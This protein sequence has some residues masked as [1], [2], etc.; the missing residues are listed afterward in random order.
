MNKQIVQDYY[1]KT[2]QSS[3][4]LKTDACATSAAPPAHIREALAAVHDDV[5]SRY[6][7]CGIAI[8]TQLEGLNILDLGSGSGRDVYALAKLA[9]PKGRVTGVD[10]TPEQLAV[11][12]EHEAWHADA[13]GYKEPTTRFIEGD[14]EK[15]ADL[16]LEP[17]SFD[18]IVSNCVINLCADKPAVFRAAYDLLKPGGEL[19]FSD[20]YA[21]R[22]VPDALKEDPVLLGECLSGALYWTDFLAMAKQ[23]GFLDPRVVEHRPLALLDPRIK[24]KLA[25]TRF[26][27]VTAR[28]FKLPDLEPACEDYGQAVIYKGGLAGAERSFEL[29]AEHQIEV[30]HVF[31]VCGNTRD[32]LMKTRFA[33][34]FEVIGDGTT[35]YGPFPGCKPV[36]VFAATDTESS[37]APVGG[38]C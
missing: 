1:G 5:S 7:G 13:F 37:P 12:R 24:E 8:P 38:C 6:Y 17:G 3:M 9:G 23:S 28:L 34:S 2:L 4:D 16:D 30:G 21:D 19:Y 25:P 22:R 26:A 11:A 33:D 10:M 18:L 35:H 31:P 14:L 15:L 29:D 27:S 32:M 36:D 20:V